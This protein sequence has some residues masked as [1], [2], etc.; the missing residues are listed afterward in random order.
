MHGRTAGYL[1]DEAELHIFEQSG[2]FPWIE[3]PDVFF[4][5]VCSWLRQ[6]KGEQLKV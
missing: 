5:A 1:P 3:E 4:N 2:H 6:Q